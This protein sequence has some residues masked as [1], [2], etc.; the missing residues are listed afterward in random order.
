MF[1]SSSTRAIVFGTFVPLLA[2]AQPGGRRRFPVTGEYGLT[3]AKAKPIYPI[4]DGQP[5]LYP[6]QYSMASK[7]HDTPIILMRVILMRDA[8]EGS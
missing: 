5:D 2:P 1:R 7:E 8:I 6:L 4:L 3:P